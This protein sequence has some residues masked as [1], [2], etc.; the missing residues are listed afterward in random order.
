ML[1]ESLKTPVLLIAFNR[2]ELTSRVFNQIRRA[3]PEK[4][5]FAVDGPRMDR[6]YDFERCDEVKKL[7]KQVDW[8]CEVMTMFSDKNLGCKFGPYSAMKWFFE[9]VEDGIILEDDALPDMS[10]FYFCEELLLKYKNDDRIAS[11]SGNNFQFGRNKTGDSYYFSH[12][13]H[14]CGW[15]TWRRAWKE[16]DL[17]IKNWPK[18]KSTKWLKSI[19][20]KLP[21]RLYWTLIFNAV[22][23]GRMDSAWDYQWTFMV[24]TKKYLSIIPSQ[25]LILNIGFGSEDATHTKRKSKLSEISVEQMHFPLKHPEIIKRNIKADDFTQ[26]NNYVLWKEIGVEI[27]KWLG[28]KVLKKQQV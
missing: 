17:E 20:K 6:P 14:T 26:K 28:K 9:N 23:S 12:F 19:F 27:A 11:I 3:K 24:W 5:Y 7:V 10:F 15:A 2:P 1:K 22:Y 13:S 8:Q 25:N 18:L 4:L 21:V 16:Y